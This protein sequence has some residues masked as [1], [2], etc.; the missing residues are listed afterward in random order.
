MA[1][2]LL[3]SEE[4][5]ALTEGV[6]DGSIPVDTGFNTTARVKKHDLASEDS[7]LGVNITSIDM[8]NERFIRTFRL[9]LVEMLRTSPKVNPNQV[10]IVRFGD[11]LKGLKAPLSVNV[12]R[13]NPLRGNAIVVIDPTV[14]FS[15]LD[16]FFGG[17]GKGVGNLPPGRLFT[18]TESRIINMILEV[19]FKSLTDAWAAVLPVEFELVSSEI[20]PQFAQ[21]A[22]ENDL[23]ILTR[24]DAE[25]KLES[26]GFIDLVYPY[27][28]LKPI[29][30]KLRSRVQSGDGNEESDKQWR[31]ELEDAVDSASL[32]ARV[33]LGSIES[34][35]G[36]IEA[37]KEGD[38]LFFKKPELALL[39]VNGLPAFDVQVGSM[40]A[41][42]AVQI[43]RA[44]IPGMQ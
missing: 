16:S 32:E 21:I 17:F 24:F 36:D 26:H 5:A 38:V 1:T 27:A 9:G 7:S 12:V 34:S 41:Q 40:G 14:V 6:M 2:N 20:N 22:D 29:R 11:Y 15:S 42:T 3:T 33:L 4:L 18:P 25:S 19:F 13:M 10:E 28:S 39:Q 35:F 8:I 23:V 37:M 44:C 43:E 30:E 31:L